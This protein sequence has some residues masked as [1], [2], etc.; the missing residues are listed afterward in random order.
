MV[1]M[2]GTNIIRKQYLFTS[3]TFYDEPRIWFRMF[4]GLSMVF[5][6][7][8]SDIA[9]IRWEKDTVYVE[10]V[11]C[12][13]SW[14]ESCLSHTITYCKLFHLHESINL[15]SDKKVI[16]YIATFSFR[17]NCLF[18]FVKRNT[19]KLVPDVAYEEI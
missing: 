4:L 5:R 9:L 15:V 12:K 6:Q 8:S 14:V 2:N 11:C 19:I 13:H 1:Q 17:E 7:E 18:T 16:V 10:R 3:S